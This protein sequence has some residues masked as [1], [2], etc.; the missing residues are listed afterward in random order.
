MK[1]RIVPV[2]AGLVAA[3]GIAI[4]AASLA[5]ADPTSPTSTLAAYGQVAPGQGETP[6][7]NGNTDPSKPMRSDEKLLTGDVAAKVTAAAKA[8]EPTATIQRVETD[9]DGVYEAHMVR[10]DGTQIIVQIDKSYAVTNVQ[11]GGAGGPGGEAGQGAPPAAPSAE[12][13]STT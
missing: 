11:V 7:G 2:A 1:I 6:Q 12:S 10:A 13:S 4:T 5:S 8:K 9:S 3:A